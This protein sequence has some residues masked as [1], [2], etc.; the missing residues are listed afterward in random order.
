MPNPQFTGEKQ[1]ALV[2]VKA[3]LDQIEKRDKELN[4]RSTRAKEYLGQLNIFSQ[5]KKGE[6]HKV[7]ES[8]ELTRLK[9]EHMVKIMDFLPK[10]V[11]ELRVVLQAYPLSLPKKDQEAIVNAVKEFFK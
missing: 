6:L 5:A 2:D 3:L 7:L 8:L 11:E 4:Y 9:E 10:T 1:L